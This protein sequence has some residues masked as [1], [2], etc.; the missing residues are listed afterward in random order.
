MH[1]GDASFARSFDPCTSILT[2]HRR[3]K[4][5]WWG[6]RVSITAGETH[7]RGKKQNW[8]FHGRTERG[9]PRATASRKGDAWHVQKRKEVEASVPARIRE[10]RFGCPHVD[11][12]CRNR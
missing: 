3:R 5:R 10:F 1:S 12:R 7:S 11:C 8:G 2:M 9:S 4:P 6:V